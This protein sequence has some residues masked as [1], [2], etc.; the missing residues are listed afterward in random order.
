MSRIET[1][2]LTLMPYAA[3][4]LQPLHK[5]W[6]SAGVRRYLF[7]DETIPLDFVSS[8][9]AS[10]ARSFE[11]RGWG[12]WAAR[13]KGETALA[14]FCG[15]RPF[16]DP[17]QTELLF[18]VAEEHWGRG[19]AGEMSRALIALAFDRWGFD[20]VQGSTDAPNAASIRVMEKLGMR[21]MERKSAEGLDTVFYEIR[22]GEFDRAGLAF[23]ALP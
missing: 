6:T 22:P 9:L 1:D 2:R 19:L 14:A 12:Q 16:H 15:F 13:L 10:N 11:T 3:D 8:E 17:P 23:T 5:L 18:G 20:R 7:D 4:D 21:F